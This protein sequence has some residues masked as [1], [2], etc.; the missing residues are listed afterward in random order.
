VEQIALREVYQWIGRMPETAATHEE[1]AVVLLTR[2]EAYVLLLM[3][4]MSPMH[5]DP[6]AEAA[7]RKVADACR[8]VTPSRDPLE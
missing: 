4:M 1:E 6:V 7:M 3:C 2:E 8:Q 5:L